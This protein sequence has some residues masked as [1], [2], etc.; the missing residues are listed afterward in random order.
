MR[1]GETSATAVATAL[2]TQHFWFLSSFPSFLFELFWPDVTHFYGNCAFH[3]LA[4][5]MQHA[6]VY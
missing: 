4:C 6:S 2:T 3:V 5:M 1:H